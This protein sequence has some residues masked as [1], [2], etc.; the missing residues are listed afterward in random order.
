MTLGF[1]QRTPSGRVA[2]QAAYDH[3]GLKRPGEML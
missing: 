2:L 3:L 1:L